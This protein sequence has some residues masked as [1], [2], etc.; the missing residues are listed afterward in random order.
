MRTHSRE[1]CLSNF[2]FPSFGFFSAKAPSMSA[3]LQAQR[4]QTWLGEKGMCNRNAHPSFVFIHCPGVNSQRAVPMDC[5]GKPTKKPARH[6]G[7]EPLSLHRVSDPW[8]RSAQESSSGSP[9]NRDRL[10]LS[11]LQYLNPQYLKN[12]NNQNKVSRE[13]PSW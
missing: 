1:Q 8:V 9:L 13:F 7:A 2:S 12:S 4:K 6:A 5:S 3:M 10:S 11:T